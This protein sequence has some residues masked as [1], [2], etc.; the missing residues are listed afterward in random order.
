MVDTDTSLK[1]IN[2]LG[3]LKRRQVIIAEIFEPLVDDCQHFTTL[4][5]VREPNSGL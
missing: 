2:E 5:V 4:I 3:V 1:L